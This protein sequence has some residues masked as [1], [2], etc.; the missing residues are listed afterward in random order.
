MIIYKYALVHPLMSFDLPIGARVLCVQMQHDVPMI[1]ILL[2]KDET[3][4]LPRRF[5]SIATGSPFDTLHTLNY[6]GTVITSKDLVWH[7][8]EVQE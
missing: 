8:F 6:L 4:L 3:Q 5:V 1:W 2:D 7:I